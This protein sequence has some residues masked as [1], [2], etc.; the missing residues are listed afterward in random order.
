VASGLRF[1]KFV[2][3]LLFGRSGQA[4]TLMQLQ[5]DYKQTLANGAQTGGR[6]ISKEASSKEEAL[7]EVECDSSSAP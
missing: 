2:I 7:K 4:R 6:F 5:I 3:R 1:P